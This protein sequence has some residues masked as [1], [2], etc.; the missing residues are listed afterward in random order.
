[1]GHRFA[2]TNTDFFFFLC[3]L[4]PTH[5][6]WA[7]PTFVDTRLRHIALPL[8][9]GLLEGFRAEIA[10]CLVKVLDSNGYF[11]HKQPQPADGV[12]NVPDPEPTSG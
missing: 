1:M 6:D 5:T 8:M 10:Q 12:H 3:V 7:S 2:Q 4:P 9:I 11:G